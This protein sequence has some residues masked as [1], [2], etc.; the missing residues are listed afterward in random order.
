MA[1]KMYQALQESCGPN[2]CFYRDK[3]YELDS[4]SPFV[5][6]GLSRGLFRDMTPTFTTP[7]VTLPSET[8][9]NPLEEEIVVNGNGEIDEVEDETPIVATK[10]PR[11]GSH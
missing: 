2:G 8:T 1:K 3:F 6:S 10:K 4:E 11:R 5:Q 9:D 7:T